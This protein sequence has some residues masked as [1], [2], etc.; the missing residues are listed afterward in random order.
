MERYTALTRAAS[1]AIVSSD[2]SGRITEWNPAAER[3]FG[4]GTDDVVGRSIDELF[5]PGSHDALFAQVEAAAQGAGGAAPA[6][7]VAWR[8]SGE[9]FVVEAAVSAWRHNGR[10][11]FTALMRDITRDKAVEHHL[12]SLFAAVADL[13]AGQVLAGRYALERLVRRDRFGSLYEATDLEQRALVMVRVLRAVWADEDGAPAAPSPHPH[14]AE[15][16]AVG[17]TDQGLP[18][19]VMEH[20]SGELVSDR[21]RRGRPITAAEATAWGLAVAEALA[22]AHAHGEVHGRLCTSSLFLRNADTPAESVVVLN[23]DIGQLVPIA[24]LTCGSLGVA[25]GPFCAPETRNGRAG[26]EASDLYGLAVVLGTLW[27]GTFPPGPNSDAPLL[28]WAVEAVPPELAVLVAQALDPR[29]N[30]RPGAD[31]FVAAIGRVRARGV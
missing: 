4:Y 31:A 20:L 28:D 2:A 17:A 15:I 16:L 24:A 22:D 1:D 10:R 29:P 27:S 30:A 14:T 13:L 7:L 9:E 26:S 5:A 3:A 8:Q 23:F 25:L 6:E 18:Y 21:L 12:E 19:A 11:F